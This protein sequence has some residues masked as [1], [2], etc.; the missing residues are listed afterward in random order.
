MQTDVGDVKKGQKLIPFLSCGATQ[1]G[2]M[3]HAPHDTANLGVENL[4]APTKYEK[5]TTIIHSLLEQ[6]A[7]TS[8]D[9][10]GS[11]SGVLALLSFPRVYLTFLF[12]YKTL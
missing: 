10:P 7:A 11:L 3:N 1:P 6:V 4:F 12:N 8:E 9:R 2:T 5:K